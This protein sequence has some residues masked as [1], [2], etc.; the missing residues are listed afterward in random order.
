ME[1]FV[2]FAE[3]TIAMKHLEADHFVIH[4]ETVSPF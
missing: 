1:L 2:E 4:S 3:S